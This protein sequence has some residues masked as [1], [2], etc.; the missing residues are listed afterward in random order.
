MRAISDDG[1]GRTAG[2]EAHAPPRARARPAR[3]SASGRPL[4]WA[5]AGFLSGVLFWHFVGFWGFVSTIAFNGQAEKPAVADRERKPART[6]DG[7]E[8][9][10]PATP[11]NSCVDLRIERGKGSVI[12]ATCEG[13]LAL[14]KAGPVA[15]RGDLATAQPP[16]QTTRP[17]PSVAG[18]ATRI[19]SSPGAPEVD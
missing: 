7:A 9:A 18:W 11:S 6:V 14:V 3:A 13:T 4:L 16:T 17:P 5:G 19:K 10:A 8:R 2:R 12:A 1:T 15:S